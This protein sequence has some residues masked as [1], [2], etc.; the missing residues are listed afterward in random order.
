MIA[1]FKVENSRDWETYRKFLAPDI[2]W[3]LY[4]K[5]TKMISGIDDYLK[6]I[7]EAYVLATD[8]TFSCEPFYQSSDE[9]RI[10]TI[11]STNFGKRSCDIFEFS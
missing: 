8:Q 7:K 3:T 2:V 6:T 1:F 11:L 9:K 5:Q 10:V 4:S